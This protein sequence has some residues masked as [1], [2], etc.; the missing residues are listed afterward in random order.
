MM[1]HQAFKES[2]NWYNEHLTIASTDSDDAWI[3]NANVDRATMP[4]RDPAGAK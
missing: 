1:N 2:Q 4:I 3:E